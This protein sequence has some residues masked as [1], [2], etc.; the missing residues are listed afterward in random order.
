MSR[1]VLVH[2]AWHGGWCWER[3]VPA[4]RADGYRVETP[5]L[6]GLGDR[7]RELEQS[8]GL[9]THVDELVALLCAGSEPA[10]LVGHSYGG[11]VAR[12][13]ADRARGRVRTLVL[14][15]GWV[16]EHGTSMLTLAPDWMAIAFRRAA[17]EQGD[18]WRI[19]PP[20]PSMLVNTD[21]DAAW[22]RARMTDQPLRTFTE[23]TRLTGAVREVPTI[24]I[25][26]SA[27]L[28]P[29]GEWAAG[30]GASVVTVDGAHDLMI[31]S[32]SEL[33]RELQRLT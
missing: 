30:I 24:A 28:V 15:E 7:A 21:L 29:F 23:P 1:L 13:A 8:I 3:V 27:P 12:E 2:G 5:T 32:P 25:V 6:R 26:S 19:P 31:T 17:E 16:G 4:L 20:D 18:G 14:V 10:V 11:L 22:L 9:R 33:T